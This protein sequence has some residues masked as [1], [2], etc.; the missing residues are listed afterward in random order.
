MTSSVASGCN[1]PPYNYFHLLDQPL[2][3]LYQNRAKIIWRKIA[4]YET[5]FWRLQ[6]TAREQKAVVLQT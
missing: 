1:S 3:K 5:L 2:N 4:R 6:A